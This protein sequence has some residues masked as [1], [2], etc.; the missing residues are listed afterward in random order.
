MRLL[1]E[2][3]R[4]EINGI[5]IGG[6]RGL[7]PS[8]DLFGVAFGRDDLGDL[9][10]DIVRKAGF[11]RRQFGK[12]NVVLVVEIAFAIAIPRP[13]RIF[14]NAAFASAS[15]I[16]AMS[17][18]CGCSALAAV[19]SAGSLQ[20]SR[21]AVVLREVIEVRSSGSRSSSVS[22]FTHA[23]MAATSPL[24]IRRCRRRS[25]ARSPARS[26]DVFSPPPACGRRH[27]RPG[28]HRCAE[29]RAGGCGSSPHN[30]PAGSLISMQR[31]FSNSGS[32]SRSEKS[33]SVSAR[34]DPGKAIW[35]ATIA[36]TNRRIQI[37]G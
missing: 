10:A 3:A 23:I 22:F 29:P 2:S 24:V 6:R 11:R 14:A 4:T 27:D 21:P 26:G 25:T 28:L 37:P 8:K 5:R 17:A 1:R 31:F 13:P 33:A 30:C 35:A 36:S 18:S 34:T 32:T 16:P 12:R 9:V 19:T 15:F 7:R 20:I